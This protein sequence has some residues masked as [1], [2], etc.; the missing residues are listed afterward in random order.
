VNTQ[1]ILLIEDNADSR[2]T[3]RMVLEMYGH[4]VVTAE[5]GAEGVRKALTGR[6]P[7]AIVDIGLPLLTGYE[8][9]RQLR[10]T[11][12]GGI[13]LIALTGY[14]RPEDRR[15]SRE[16]GFDVHLCKPADLDPLLRLLREKAP[17]NIQPAPATVRRPPAA[18]TMLRSNRKRTGMG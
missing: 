4:R 3:M 1:S 12:G 17:P 15:R 11:L 5:D 10:S 16:A 2:E 6:P 7:V 18:R 13:F 8:V 9:A 14:N